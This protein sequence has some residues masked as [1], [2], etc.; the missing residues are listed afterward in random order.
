[1]LRKYVDNL[2][3]CVCF[4]DPLTGIVEFKYKGAKT[5]TCVQ[6]GGVYII[7]RDETVTMLERVSNEEFRVR[8]S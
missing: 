2:G 3:R 5:R 4:A 1:M 8:T 6:I 7:E